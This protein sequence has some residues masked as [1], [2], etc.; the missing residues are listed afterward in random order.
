MFPSPETVLPEREK[1]ERKRPCR[2]R[3]T[4]IHQVSSTVATP[5]VGARSGP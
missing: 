2:A 5:V 4:C 1:L 3:M